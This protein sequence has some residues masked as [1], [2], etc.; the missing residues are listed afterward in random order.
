MTRLLRITFIDHEHLAPDADLALEAI[1]DRIRG[2]RRSRAAIGGAVAAVVATVVGALVVANSASDTAGAP[3]VRPATSSHPAP[4]DW[5]PDPPEGHPLSL[6]VGA[7]WLPAGAVE[8]A[9]ILRKGEEHDIYT[10]PVGG[11][12]ATIKF[13]LKPMIGP[14]TYPSPSAGF[15]VNNHARVHGYPAAEKS[16]STSYEAMFDVPH[17]LRVYAHVTL[18]QAMP[19]FSIAAIGR[20]IANSLVID[21]NVPLPL[22]VRP[23]YM[24]H[25][26]ELSQSMWR[27]P[28]DT[29]L[30][31]SVSDST[32][33]PTIQLA[34]ST[35]SWASAQLP[36][37]QTSAGWPVQGH[38]THVTR[39]DKTRATQVWIE[40]VGPGSATV[41]GVAGV[42]L[43][44]LY[45]VADGLIFP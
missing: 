36:A 31:Y 9:R 19:T 23:R 37:G 16:S 26:L 6:D 4:S 28:H 14:M 22:E 5:P 18:E 12:A 2:R 40:G 1:Q 15:T 11:G 13:G 21:R 45:R 24:T 17:R 7:G 43:A 10:M 8:S 27:P 29:T 20:H 41:V 25:G 30:T 39:F 35:S 33:T 44:E 38:P 34:T 3:A 42:S 32:T